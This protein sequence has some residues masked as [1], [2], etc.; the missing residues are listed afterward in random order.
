MRQSREKIA[1]LE[2]EIM[3]ICPVVRGDVDLSAPRR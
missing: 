1:E 2:R 3:Q